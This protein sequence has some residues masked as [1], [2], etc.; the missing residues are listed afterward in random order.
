MP[1]P[2]PAPTT[3]KSYSG[4]GA[5]SG[6]GSGSGT[7]SDPQEKNMQYHLEKEIASA[8][9]DQPEVIMASKNIL[10]LVSFI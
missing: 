5:C 9:P 8:A 3:T 10:N 1:P 2:E 7:G 4:S 6:N